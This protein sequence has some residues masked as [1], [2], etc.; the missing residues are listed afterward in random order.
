MKLFRSLFVISQK[1]LP[2]PP[3]VWYCWA[4]HGEELKTYGIMIERSRTH[5]KD[6]SCS[7][8][9]N[10]LTGGT[11]IILEARHKNRTALM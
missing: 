1:S 2:T 8:Y 4:M 7:S 10:H 5:L 11:K 9:S 3:L 6:S